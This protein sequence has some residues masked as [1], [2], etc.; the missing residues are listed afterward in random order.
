M[1]LEMLALLALLCILQGAAARDVKGMQK[2]LRNGNL[3]SIS[4][5]GAGATTTT[6]AH[7][8]GA[9][10]PPLSERT[11]N[12]NNE[13]VLDGFDWYS[14]KLMTNLSMSIAALL[15]TGMMLALAVRRERAAKSISAT[16]HTPLELGGKGNKAE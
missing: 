7:K 5:G 12:N 11:S 3:G 10:N 14:L 2:W 6:L 8:S 16:I 9:E 1:K 13:P 4:T 15:V